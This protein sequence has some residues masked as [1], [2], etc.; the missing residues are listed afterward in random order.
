MNIT[1]LC[2]I[3]LLVVWIVLGFVIAVPAGWVH[4]SYAGAATL[5]VRRVLLGAPRFRS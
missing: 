4:L 1:L 2:A 3:V 5:Y